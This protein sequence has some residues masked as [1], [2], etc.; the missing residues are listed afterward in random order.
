MPYNQNLLLRIRNLLSTLPY[1]VEEKKM[2]RGITFMIN[3][4]M[5]VSVSGD[6]LMCR[7]DP[8]VHDTVSLKPGFRKM[9]MKGR[10]YTGYAYIHPDFL[11]TE[12]ELA[13]WVNLALA[14]NKT[15]KE[16][17]KKKKNK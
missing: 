6:E 8:E 13:Y 5:C 4:K 12:V 1:K 2:F 16:E 10:E 14:Y 17:P 15:L 9:I 7:Y 11:E 3:D